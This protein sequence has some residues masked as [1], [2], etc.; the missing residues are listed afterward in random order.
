M[1]GGLLFHRND[2]LLMALHRFLFGFAEEMTFFF[3]LSVH[4]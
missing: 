4:L 1:S 2:D 3:V